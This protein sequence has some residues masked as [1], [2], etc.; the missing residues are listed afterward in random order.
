MEDTR[1]YFG[2]LNI[3]QA[4]VKGIEADDVI[5]FLAK[6]LVNSGYRV[7]ILSDDKD[8]FSL[9]SKSIKIWRPCKNSYVKR[10]NIIEAFK[11]PPKFFTHLFALMGQ[12]KDFIP[13]LCDIDLKNKKLIKC[14]FGVVK[15]AALL[16][17]MID[18]KKTFRQ[19]VDAAIQDMNYKWRD[20]LKRNRRQVFASLKLM[21]IRTNETQYSPEELAKVKAI[22]N[23]I[24][25]ASKAP[26]TISKAK[27]EM[28][29]TMLE[30]RKVPILAILKRTGMKIQ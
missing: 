29:K 23:T 4:A 25:G 1:N 16:Q 28:L 8:F 20:N 9:Y 13:G 19:C 18:G 14:G 5:G 6:T 27:V 10:A 2:K 11:V 15:A 12:E 3:T 24:L 26:K 22:S 30:I 17:P 7:T 21:K